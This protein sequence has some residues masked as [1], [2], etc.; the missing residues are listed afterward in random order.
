MHMNGQMK[1]YNEKNLIAT[2]FIRQNN[3][4]EKKSS[5][6]F[7][8]RRYASYVKENGLKADEITPKI[9]SMFVKD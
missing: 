7:D 1:S 2:E 3:P 6:N 8:L 5:L 4:Y 9:L